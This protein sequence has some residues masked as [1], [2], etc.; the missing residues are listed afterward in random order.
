MQKAEK[1]MQLSKLEE[2]CQEKLLEM[3]DTTTAATALR[4][5][6]ESLRAAARG[7]AEIEQLNLYQKARRKATEIQ[8]EQFE[9]Q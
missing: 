3:I 9:E 2:E 5:R 4:H 1:T 6:Q 7:E 8:L